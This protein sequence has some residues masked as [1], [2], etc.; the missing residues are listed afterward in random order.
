MKG[1]VILEYLYNKNF[2]GFVLS[3]LMNNTDL[4][5]D[6][7][8]PLDKTDFEPFIVHNI[9]FVCISNLADK[10]VSK[11]T[12][13]EIGEF[14]KGYP[15]Q[16][17][18][19]LNEL[20]GDYIDY[21][22][23]LI[24]LDNPKAFDFYY[25]EVRK[26]SLLREYRDSGNSIK[27]FFDE[28]ADRI[29]TEEAKLAQVSILDILDY[30]DKEQGKRRQ[31][32]YIEDDGTTYKQAGDNGREILK[33]FKDNPMRGL[34]FE[35]KYLTTF[36]GGCEKKQLYIRSG[37]TSSGKS[38]S[39]IG[40]MACLCCGEV[41]DLDKN[42]W[43]KNPNGKHK[44]LYIGCEM[45]LDKEVDPIFWA[46]ISGVESS[47]IIHGKTTEEE[48]KR[49]ERAIDII[50]DDCIYLYNMPRFNIKK[51]EEKIK[52]HKQLH[53]IDY[54]CFDYISI[55]G[56]L[57][58][59]F[60][61]NRGSGV[62]TRGDEVLLELS[63]SLKDMALEYD[64][65]IITATQVNADIKDYK[66]RDYQ[67]LR[68]GKAVADKA[69]GGSISMPI[70]AQELKLVEPIVANLNAHAEFGKMVQPNFVETVYKSRF[71]EYP[72]ECKIFS[73]FNLGNMR[74]RELFVTDK[75]F[76]L[77]EVPKTIINNIGA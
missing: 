59:E 44:G 76:N 13:K 74:K 62:A 40:D 10:G 51:I 70:T 1:Y 67:V 31:K 56:D 7:R 61:K 45:E 71:S 42:E 57:I 17:Q 53:N 28:K 14:L 3:S 54:V 41:Y 19:L 21:L 73:E 5:Y 66:M 15:A 68:G 6:S 18:T 2:S 35:S 58:K 60:V 72:K 77:I 63:K 64:V 39:L 65:A 29:E 50:N 37:D 20:N 38:R 48:D 52:L 11:I 9:L 26:R 24:E 33:W 22:Y 4:L 47:K 75:D 16:E 46:Y 8:Y 30:Y 43:F 36:W 49:I 69:T 55:N 32:Y 25:S 12:P 23:E 27:H 34:S